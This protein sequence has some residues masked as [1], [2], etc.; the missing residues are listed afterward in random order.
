MNADYWN[1]EDFSNSVFDGHIPPSDIIMAPN[2]YELL[3]YYLKKSFSRDVRCDLPLCI[4]FYL[5]G[6]FGSIRIRR[7]PEDK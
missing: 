2:E 3:V 7:G 6:P 5:Y 1:P 4:E